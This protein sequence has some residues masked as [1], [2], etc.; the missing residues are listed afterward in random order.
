MST[1]QEI[2]AQI[3]S[4]NLSIDQLNQVIEAVKYARAQLGR[5]VARTISIGSNVRFT[6]RDGQ[7]FTGTVQGIKI[8]NAV[9]TTAQGRFQV[10]MSLLEAA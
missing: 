8:K 2:N 1:A 4:S 3:I 10:P 9:V 7:V 6:A 5:Q